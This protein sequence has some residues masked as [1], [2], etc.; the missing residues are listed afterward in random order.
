MSPIVGGDTVVVRSDGIGL[1]SLVAIRTGHETVVRPRGVGIPVTVFV[2]TAGNQLLGL[3][4]QHFN[5]ELG[6]FCTAAVGTVGGHV[7][8]C[9]CEHDQQR[10]QIL[11]RVE[12]VF[13]LGIVSIA[14]AGGTVVTT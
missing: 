7:L 6:I 14:A 8:F 1:R 2:I 9:E 11:L 13:N 12:P 5:V 4:V 10:T 3:P